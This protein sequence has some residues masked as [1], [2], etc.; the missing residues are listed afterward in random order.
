MADDN[1]YVG[2]HE[3]T[4]VPAP[5]KRNVVPNKVK[6]VAK[7]TTAE[8]EVK[9]QRPKPRPLRR[10][11]AVEDLANEAGE[12]DDEAD[13]I[14]QHRERQKVIDHG[15]P[16]ELIGG[17]IVDDSNA[18]SDGGPPLKK[19]KK[20]RN[21]EV[22]VKEVEVKEK[23]AKKKKESI[24]DA[25]EAAQ[26]EDYGNTRDSLSRKRPS[27]VDNMPVITWKGKGK[28]ITGSN[29]N[30]DERGHRWEKATR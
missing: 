11:Y 2:I 10:T 16:A 12:S 13:Q 9:H 20:V 23:K 25:I 29:Q 5:K 21:K 3:K 15:S 7:S 28:P 8:S 6:A 18:E 30:T 17:D 22:E 24:R 19:T 1:V 27:H 4:P 14:D 26:Q